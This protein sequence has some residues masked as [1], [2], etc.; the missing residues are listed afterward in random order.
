M[1]GPLGAVVTA[2]A[3]V[4]GVVAGGVVGGVVVV[5]GTL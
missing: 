1:T 2:G 5:V 3:V 4:A